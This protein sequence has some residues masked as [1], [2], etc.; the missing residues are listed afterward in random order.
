MGVKIRGK[1][2]SSKRRFW[3]TLRPAGYAVIGLLI[4]CQSGTA[5]DTVSQ[6]YL[7]RLSRVLDTPVT[8][9][10]V[11][12]L[13]RYPAKRELQ[14]PFA[15]QRVDF[16]RFL[17][18]DI[19]DFQ[20]LIGGRNSSF[21][22]VMPPSQ[23]LV[24]EHAWAHEWYQ[25]LLPQQEQLEEDVLAELSVIAA[26]KD[27]ERPTH[28][29][30]ATWASDEFRRLF[31]Q[32]V[33]PYAINETLPVSEVTTAIQYFQQIS[34]SQYQMT[35]IRSSELEQ[36]LAVLHHQQALGRWAVSVQQLVI[37]L[38]QSAVMIQQRL[39]QRPF[40]PQGVPTDKARVL[41][42]VF[43]KV[44]AAQLQPYLSQLTKAGQAWL[45]ALDDL[46]RQ[47]SVDV[48]RFERYWQAHWQ[49]AA[50][51]SLWQQLLSARDAHTQAWQDILGQCGLMPK[52][53]D[54]NQV[55]AE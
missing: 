5:L 20:R 3:L 17:R 1:A 6:D 15:D 10:L 22:K 13:A 7:K 42:T 14:Q 26:I 52:V 48:R 54:F 29:W 4:A 50:P 38:Q 44:Y 33:E 47:Q 32:A 39:T 51:T 8:E 19:C 9:E 40:C 53:E 21:G 28:R 36:Q 11:M 34:Q 27:Q 35:L 23:R 16:L 31:S 25:C 18:L 49:M 43:F 55:D 45:P 12:P 41:Q 2:A 37:S 24:Y 46:Q 30:N